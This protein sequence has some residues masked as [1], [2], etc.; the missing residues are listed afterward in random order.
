MGLTAQRDTLS[1]PQGR[2]AYQLARPFFCL[3][4]SSRL[5]RVRTRKQNGRMR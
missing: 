3:R 1:D 2:P 5:R 4:T